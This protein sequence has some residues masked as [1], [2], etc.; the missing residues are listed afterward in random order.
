M[1][2]AKGLTR[3][4]E[5]QDDA[6]LHLCKGLN[7]WRLVHGNTC[8]HATSP[9]VWSHAR[10]CIRTRTL[11]IDTRARASWAS[12]VT[13]WNWKMWS[14]GFTCGG[15]GGGMS[16]VPKDADLL[17]DNSGWLS[18]RAL[19]ADGASPSLHVGES[20]G[21]APQR[22]LLQVSFTYNSGSS[23]VCSPPRRNPGCLSCTY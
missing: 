7:A 11:R 20:K 2:A 13:L 1:D 19:L 16:L 5:T 6:W 17:P 14:M 15:T 18:S 21:L 3:T 22:C 9:H 8:T 23:E 10:A 4:S 12:G